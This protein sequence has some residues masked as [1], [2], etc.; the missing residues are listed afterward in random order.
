MFDSSVVDRDTD[1]LI[2]NATPGCLLSF[3]T[4]NNPGGGVIDG[5][6]A[7][8]SRYAYRVPPPYAKGSV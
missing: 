5:R 8:T 6:F 4:P 1:P 2:T 3:T 7:D